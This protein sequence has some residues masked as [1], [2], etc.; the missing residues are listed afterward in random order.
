M[1]ATSN[2]DL[3]IF[4]VSDSHSILS[5]MMGSI[6]ALFLF[7]V[8]LATSEVRSEKPLKLCGREYIRTV[9]YICASSRW[10]RDLEGIPL[11][12]QAER[13]NY[14]WLPNEHEV[15]ERSMAQNLP[16]VDSTGEG[17]LQYEQLPTDGLG[18]SKKFSVM[19][20]R[21]LQTLCCNNGC[22]MADLSTLC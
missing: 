12:Q 2:L 17:S 22:S 18:G 9:I 21:D 14:F 13:G 1:R 19:S 4:T 15:S 8:L 10:R 16:K 6:S 7:S 11:A 20:R 3:A 5:K